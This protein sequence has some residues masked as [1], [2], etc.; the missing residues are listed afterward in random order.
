MHYCRPTIKQIFEEWNK[1]ELESY[2]IEITSIIFSKKDDVKDDDGFVVDKI[3]DKTGMKGTGR[4]TVQDAAERNIAIPTITSALEARYIA[5]KKQDRV[6]YYAI[7]VLKL[8][9]LTM[10]YTLYVFIHHLKY[11][12]VLASSILNGPIDIPLV[13]SSQIIEDCRHALFAAKLC[14]YSQGFSLIKSAS[15]QVIFCFPLL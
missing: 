9:F 8:S 10:R 6:I 13:E 5:S 3:L 4:W 11:T 1:S 12:K 7:I 14:S 15:D 2:L